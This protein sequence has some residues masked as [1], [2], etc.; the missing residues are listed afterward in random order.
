MK[1]FTQAI[2]LIGSI[3]M[4]GCHSG[5]VNWNDNIP[6]KVKNEIKSCNDSILVAIV[7][8][9]SQKLKYFFSDK[10]IV[11]IG[12]GFDSV[13]YKM[14]DV[15]RSPNY[16]VLD[17]CLA[18]NTDRTKRDTITKRDGG[19]HAYKINFDAR[20]GENYVSLLLHEVDDG[21]LLITCIYGNY[22]GRWKLEV[23]RIGRYSYFGNTA[24]DIYNQAKEMY[25]KGDVMNAANLITLVKQP[26]TPAFQ[27]F[28]YDK[29]NEI[30]DFTRKML[31]A[32]DTVF[33]FPN[34]IS[35][36]KSE[37]TIFNIRPLPMKEG[38]FPVITYGTKIDLRDTIS[39][40]KE[41]AEL[42]KI[43]G[44]L[45]PGMEKDNKYIFFQVYQQTSNGIK[46]SSHMEFTMNGSVNQP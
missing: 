32:A 30:K 46:P 26:L 23:F 17:E 7:E 6:L 36:L 13:A 43:I 19:N 42:Q 39:V 25:E 22:D 24:I 4:S 8:N 44:Q 45:F 34:L 41:N 11:Q 21:Q 16:S 37:P 35:E 9:N 12:N 28:Q 1:K 14:H 33:R 2:L 10:L 27:F 40:K 29:E 31:L 38:I 5:N 15:L 3:L 20:S 18:K